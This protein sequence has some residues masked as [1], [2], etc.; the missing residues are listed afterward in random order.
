MFDWLESTTEWAPVY[1][2]DRAFILV[3]RRPDNEKFVADHEFRLFK[4]TS[5]Q[6]IF[7]L[8]EAPHL[9]EETERAIRDCPHA[10]VGHQYKGGALLVLG[11]YEEA[12]AASRRAVELPPG[13]PLA[14]LYMGLA[15]EGLGRRDEALA[16]FESTL[17]LA[18][19][20][21]LAQ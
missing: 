19:E 6:A 15:L 1:Y 16:A 5:R 4:R 3:R 12:L 2:D 13:Q 18:P 10:A 20:Q 9:L 11:R 21:P 8:V 17:A 14:N 7:S